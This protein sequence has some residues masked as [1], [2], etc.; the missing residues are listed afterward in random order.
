[1]TEPIKPSRT[2]YPNP[3]QVPASPRRRPSEERAA[4][5][6]SSRTATR[7]AILAIVIAGL[8]L[9]LGVWRTL[10]TSSS[11]SPCQD[12]AWSAQ[13]A[14]T[15]LPNQ[16][17]AQ[18]TTFDINRR[19]TQ[20]AGQ[21]TGSGTGAPNILATV[22]CFPDGAADAV[23]RAAA[24]ARELGQNV[25]DRGDLSDGGYL[26]T[27]PSGASF[28]EF[29][30]GDIIVDLAASGGAT[31]TDIETIASAYDK[32]LGG[33][34]G[35]I[36]SQAPGASGDLGAASPGASDNPSGSPSAPAAP[37]LEKLLPTKVGTVDLTVDSQ[38]GTDVL[39]SDQGSRAITAALRASGKTPAD[40]RIAQAYDASQNSPLNLLAVKVNG[41]DITKVRQMVIDSW[42]AG[43]GAGVTQTP[44]TLA[45]KDWTKIDLGDGG[46][47][48][49]VRTNDGVVFV[50]TTS[51]AAQA[52]QA[53]AQMP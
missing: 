52:A 16:W 6:A 49:Y 23:S 32:A 37:E 48:D 15:E 10:T 14:A 36:S 11:S 20:F 33:D 4:I 22:T 26:A 43:S 45:G 31:T 50:I 17:S 7:L 9:G 38:L 47:I 30:H 29:R 19:T 53:A 25:T 34:G 3:G 27:D 46:D 42:L 44:T 12:T 1:M 5:A 39:Q 21:D 13:P 35:S 18:G 40:L 41:M 2:Q 51:D 24:A 28:M 8:A